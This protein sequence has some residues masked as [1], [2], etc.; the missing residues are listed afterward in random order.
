MIKYR[1]MK[2]MKKISISLFIFICLG[3]NAGAKE[4]GFS[5]SGHYRTLY[6]SSRTMVDKA[7]YYLDS[8]RLRI[9]AKGEVSDKFSYNIQYDNH[10][11]FGDY[12][13]TS[14]AD[15]RSLPS[16]QYWDLEHEIKREDEL[17][18]NHSIYRGYAL[19]RHADID[20][21]VGRQRVPWI[22][23]NKERAKCP[24][25]PSPNPHCSTT[26]RHVVTLDQPTRTGAQLDP[27][28]RC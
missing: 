9:E 4:K 18:W 24:F 22:L 28:Q 12:L 2:I 14:E 23:G 25:R 3:Q 10:F 15:A 27:C 6:L 1:L 20:L 11:A 7:R 26:A 5:L 19:I 13:S 16:E 21:T 8:N 17:I